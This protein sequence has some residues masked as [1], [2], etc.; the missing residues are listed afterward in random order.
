MLILVGSHDG[1]DVSLPSLLRSYGCTPSHGLPTVAHCVPRESPQFS[2]M[3]GDILE[4]AIFAGH[5]RRAGVPWRVECQSARISIA[6]GLA[7]SFP[8]SPSLLRTEEYFEKDMKRPKEAD[9]ADIF[10]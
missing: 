8:S 1:N 5:V 6:S 2:P 10:K 3:R 7:T 9:P 4:T